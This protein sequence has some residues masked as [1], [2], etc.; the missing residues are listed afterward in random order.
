MEDTKYDREVQAKNELKA[1]RAE[2][3]SL[4]I[5]NSRLQVTIMHL[6]DTSKLIPIDAQ[7]EHILDI[8]AVRF[9]SEE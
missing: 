7:R 6:M 2:M 9:N 3:H 1:V 4:R 5:Q 8:I